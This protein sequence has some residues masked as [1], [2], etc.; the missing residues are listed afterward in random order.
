[1]LRRLMEDAGFSQVKVYGWCGCRITDV[2]MCAGPFARISDW[3]A[4]YLPRFLHFSFLA[5]WFPNVFAERLRVIA[6]K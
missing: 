6:V 1:M 2:F 5:R 3:C 4:K